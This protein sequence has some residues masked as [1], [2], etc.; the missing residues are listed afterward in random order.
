MEGWS[1]QARF[2]ACLLFSL[3]IIWDQGASS[4]LHLK[5][6]FFQVVQKAE[7]PQASVFQ[8]WFPEAPQQRAAPEPRLAG[9]AGARARRCGGFSGWC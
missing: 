4:S 8:A 6:F 3:K 2:K 5:L 1:L 9:G 7:Q